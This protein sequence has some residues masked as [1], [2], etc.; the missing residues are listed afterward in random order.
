VARLPT[1]EDLGPRPTPVSRRQVAT[2]R[3]AG[4][5]GEAVAGTGRAGQQAAIQLAEL[6]QRR[7]AAQAGVEFARLAGEI[8]QDANQRRSN[9]APGGS[10]HLTGVR[11]YVE[12]RTGEFLSSIRDRR[13]RESFSTNVEQLRARV[14]ASEDVWEIGQRRELAVANVEETGRLLRNQL[15][16]RPDPA[17]LQNYLDVT[18]STIM[19]TEGIP[20]D[21]AERLVREQQAGLVKSYLG[22]LIEQNPSAAREIISSGALNQ[23]IDP[24][25]AARLLDNSDSEIRVREADA[26]RELAATQ[27]AARAEIDLFQRRLRDGDPTITEEELEAMQ[28]RAA[29]SQLPLDVYDIAK[30][31]V[32]HRVNREYRNATALEISTAIRALDARIAQGGEDASPDDVVARDHLQ[33]ILT[34]RQQAEEGDALGE[35]ARRGG[36]VAPVN[37]AEPASIRERLTASYAAQREIGRFQFFT[38]QEVSR[39]QELIA[40]GAQGRMQAINNVAAIGQLDPQAAIRAAREIAPE[41]ATFQHAIR[42]PANVRGLIVRGM[43]SRALLPQQL[44]RDD[45][46]LAGF[47]SISH[48][49][50]TAHIGPSLTRLQPDFVAGVLES[51]RAIYAERLRASGQSTRPDFSSPDFAAAVSTALGGSGSGGGMGRWTWGPRAADGEYPGMVLPA[52][53]SQ[54]E[55]HRRMANLPIAR[56]GGRW[57][58]G[59]INGIPASAD[60]SVVSTDEIRGQFVPMAVS[61]GVYE[62]HWSGRVLMTR[63]GRPFRLNI[64]RIEPFRA[65]P[66]QRQ[67]QQRR[68]TTQA[69]P[70]LP[71]RPA[72]PPRGPVWRAPPRGQ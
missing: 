58:S 62:F 72:N 48:A 38:P 47:N 46:T 53:M 35:H 59:A 24:D 68:P 44:E 1:I 23:W 18:R 6:D 15:Q 50:F 41:D 3:N 17:A 70:A 11:G 30:A 36:D 66:Q 57:P 31:R 60:G 27:S 42:M 5:P 8:E 7:Q 45:G 67:Q 55:F 39:Y 61:D 16:T 14:F 34:R 32:Q 21:L 25:D 13:V 20:A 10:G 26:R 49:W 56:T 33:S 69:R 52:G 19:V 51:A 28:Q 54:D 12:Q 65:P 63:E 9:P 43:E 2:V 29:A 40:S 4:A 22:G 37:L 71:Q 64:R